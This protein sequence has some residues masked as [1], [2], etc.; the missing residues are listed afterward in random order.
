MS[1][2]GDELMWELCLI[3]L[4]VTYSRTV[5]AVCCKQIGTYP[6]QVHQAWHAHSVSIWMIQHNSGMWFV[7]L[8]LMAVPQLFVYSWWV[9]MNQNQKTH[10]MIC[11]VPLSF[12]IVMIGTRAGKRCLLIVNKHILHVCRPI[13]IDE[14][15]FDV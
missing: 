14:L 9:S 1:I 2:A 12:L 5:T 13:S 11:Q 10:P 7:T 6:F 4:A 3:S 15:H 8:S